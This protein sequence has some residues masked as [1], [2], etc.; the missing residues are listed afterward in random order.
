MNRKIHVR[1]WSRAAGA[2][3]SLRSTAEKGEQARELL[4]SSWWYLANDL[5][6]ESDCSL[7]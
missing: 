5:E 4:L 1:F 6:S 2:T 7:R 3:P